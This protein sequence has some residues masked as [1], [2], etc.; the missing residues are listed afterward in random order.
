M[1]KI[2]ANMNILLTG[3]PGVGKST[4]I[5]Y[6]VDNYNGALAGV[7]SRE[8]LESGERVGFE[9]VTIDGR[10]R[11]FAH[12]NMFTDSTYRVGEFFVDVNCFDEFVVPELKRGLNEL[13]VIVLLDEI[14]RMQAFSKSFLETVNDLLSSPAHIIGTIVYDDEAFARPI[15]AHESTMVLTVTSENRDLLPRCILAAAQQAENYELFSTEQKQLVRQWAAAWVADGQL[16]Y[17]FKLFNNA[18]AYVAGSKVIFSDNEWRVAGDT[19]AH[20]L[21]VDKKGSLLCDCDLFNGRAEF[22]GLVGQ[23]SHVMSVKLTQLES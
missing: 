2:S 4:L 21:T 7:V 1:A 8:L 13:G 15:K 5:Q 20:V 18:I 23:C 19:S 6:L 3:E 9:A 11:V 16:E 10:R 14:G 22:S 12:R 17:V